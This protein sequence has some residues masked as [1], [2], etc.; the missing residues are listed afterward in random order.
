MTVLSTRLR[1]KDNFIHSYVDSA[2]ALWKHAA[3]MHML[4][5]LQFLCKTLSIKVQQAINIFN[6]LT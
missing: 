1:H 4:F 2:P 3:K 5:Q 6:T